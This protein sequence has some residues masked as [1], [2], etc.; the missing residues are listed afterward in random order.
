MQSERI[1]PGELLLSRARLRF[2]RFNKCKPYS[3][4]MEMCKLVT[5]FSNQKCKLFSGRDRRQ[6]RKAT[7]AGR[8]QQPGSHYRKGSQTVIFKLSTKTFCLPA[9]QIPN[10]TISLECKI[11]G[12][13]NQALT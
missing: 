1:I 11:T 7:T 5:V 2:I 13:T 8:R 9:F 6:I 4:L 3:G 10:E 12:V